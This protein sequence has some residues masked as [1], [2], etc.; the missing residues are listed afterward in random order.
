MQIVLVILRFGPRS[1][2]LEMRR[3][4]VR[5]D[6]ERNA[7]T[8]GLS[9]VSPFYATGRSTLTAVF[10]TGRGPTNEAGNKS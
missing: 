10:H 4:R 7:T 5:T 2:S 6:T 9:G 1:P 8:S 3:N